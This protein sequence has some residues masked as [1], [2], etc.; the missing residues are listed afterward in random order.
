MLDL[1]YSKL[2][3]IMSLLP[4]GG[5]FPLSLVPTAIQAV[6]KVMTMM[7]VLPEIVCRIVIGLLKDKFWEALF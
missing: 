3:M 5:M 4:L 6:P 7:K 1:V 2:K